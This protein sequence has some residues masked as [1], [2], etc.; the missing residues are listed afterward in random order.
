MA[1]VSDFHPFILLNGA[2][3]TFS[4]PD[5]RV[6]AVE[7]HAH[8]Y[9]DYHSAAAQAGLV[10]D[11]VSEPRLNGTPTPIVVVYR[12]YKRGRATRM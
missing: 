10:I 3:R 6:Y 9:A 7:H 1:L 12:F 5:G 8:L 4:A 11:A 2:Q